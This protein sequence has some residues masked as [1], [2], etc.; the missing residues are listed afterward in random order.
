MLSAEASTSPWNLTSPSRPASATATA[1]RS[2]ATS[3]PTN[4]SLISAMVRPPM[5]RRGSY[6]SPDHRGAAS[7][8]RVAPHRERTYG[9]S[10]LQDQG[11]TNCRVL[12]TMVPPKPRIEGKALREMLI[13]Q[14]IPV[15]E[16][17]IPRLAAFEKAAAEGLP[18]G[19]VQ[20]DR[21]AGRAWAAYVAI[22]KEIIADGF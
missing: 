16:G 14:K 12:L 7:L 18:V 15:F 9:L 22:G 10:K 13:E 8:I 17:E 1:L 5:V 6:H 20:T 19:A 21:N 3:I 2:F 11:S 4:A